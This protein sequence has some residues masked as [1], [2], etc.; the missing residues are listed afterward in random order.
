MYVPTPPCWLGVSLLLDSIVDSYVFI[1][2][3]F[4][5]HGFDHLLFLK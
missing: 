5:V 2:Y 4:I 3:H 1:Y